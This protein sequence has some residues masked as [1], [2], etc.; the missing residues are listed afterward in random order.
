MLPKWERMKP[1]RVLY[2]GVNVTPEVGANDALLGVRVVPA[3]RDGQRVL[4]RAL[5]DGEA[6]TGAAI[7]FYPYK[8]DELH[9]PAGSIQIRLQDIDRES[10]PGPDG[11]APIANTLW[12]WLT[13]GDPPDPALF[14]YLFAAAR[15]LDAA[16]ALCDAV[17]GQLADRDEPFI[18]ARTRLFGAL[19]SAEQMCVATSRAIDMLQ[20]VSGKFPGVAVALPSSAVAIAP[21]LKEI[22][23]AFEHIEDRALGNVWGKPHPDS[24]S[25]FNQADFVSKG[26]LRYASHTLDVRT[27]VLPLLVASR[28]ALLAVAAAV[29][30]AA[31]TLAPPLTFPSA[32]PGAHE[33][34]EE[35]AYFLW[36]NQTGKTWWDTD[37]NW[38]EAEKADAAEFRQKHTQP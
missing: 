15:R 10:P 24:L 31:R 6:D 29:G 20:A 4:G 2:I 25:I 33:R 11:Y 16:H 14:R 35:R 34:I 21:A 28:H 32:P 38:F 5:A 22:R 26:I 8:G 18:K 7:E 19:G 12:T 3:G 36:K 9:F 23:N 30:G 27:Q 37:S 1:Q 17:I 13:F